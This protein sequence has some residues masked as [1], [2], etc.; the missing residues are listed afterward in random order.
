MLDEEGAGLGQH[1]AFDLLALLV[2]T[3]EETGQRN[4]AFRRRGCEQ[5]QEQAGA[6]KPAGRVEAW[7]EAERHVRRTQLRFVG[8]AGRFQQRF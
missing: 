8:Q 5:L 6:A 3:V 2:L 1:P 7:G 4:G